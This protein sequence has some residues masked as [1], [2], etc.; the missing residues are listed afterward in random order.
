MLEAFQQRVD[1]VM[2]VEHPERVAWYRSLIQEW[3][4]QLPQTGV[5]D[6]MAVAWIGGYCSQ[7]GM[8]HSAPTYGWGTT[9]EEAL[10]AL[11]DSLYAHLQNDITQLQH[12]AAQWG[13]AVRPYVS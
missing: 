8:L 6:H 4:G 2:V 5:V 10:A 7:A 3:T 12:A 13:I 11:A 9:I 1:A